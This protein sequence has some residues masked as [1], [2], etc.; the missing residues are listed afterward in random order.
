MKKI[1]II[2]DD[3]EFL[4]EL[5]DLLEDADYLVV[6]ESDSLAAQKR[7]LKERPDLILVDIRMPS[8]CGFELATTLKKDKELSGIPIIAMTGFE[9]ADGKSAALK[10]KCLKKPLKPLD[11]IKEIE[12][13]L[14]E[15]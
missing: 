2:D 14:K 3:K 15:K 5:T 7:A 6:T 12:W 8:M 4:V 13:T 1:M 10:I 9:P 11:V